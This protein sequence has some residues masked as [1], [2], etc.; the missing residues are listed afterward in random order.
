[1]NLGTF[2]TIFEVS[3]KI[4]KVCKEHKIVNLVKLGF[5]MVIF[6]MCFTEF[7]LKNRYFED[8]KRNNIIY[9]KIGDLVKECGQGSFV[10]W[11]VFEDYK[12]NTLPR[13]VRFNDVIGCLGKDE[14][15]CPVSVRFS[16]KSYSEPH[17][18]GYDD[19]NYLSRLENGIIVKCLID[20]REPNCPTYTPLLLKKFTKLTNLELSTIS[21]SV[22]KDYK[23]NLIY[24]FTLTFAK[25]SINTCS[26]QGANILLDNLIRT[27]IENL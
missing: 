13:N 19:Y 24:I 21:Y 12:L 10:S 1:M 5:M 11:L 22:V 17:Q 20:D 14:K 2:Q 9:E 6:Y 15:H 23:T 8:A 4:F 3:G 7:Y 16:N 18:L 27:T 25:N 26:N